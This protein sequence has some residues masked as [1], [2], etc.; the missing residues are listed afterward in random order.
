MEGLRQRSGGPTSLVLGAAYLRHK[1]HQLE[2]SVRRRFGGTTTGSD[3]E[4]AQRLSS[5]IGGG[6]GM[7]SEQDEFR[8]EDTVFAKMKARFSL[9]TLVVLILAATT[10]AFNILVMIGVGAFYAS[11]VGSILAISVGVSQLRLE[12]IETLRQVHNWMR[13]DVNR[14]TV[15]NI[16][17]GSSMDK[18][19]TK[20]ALLRHSEQRLE[21][22]ARENNSNSQSLLRLVQTNS[23]TLEAMRQVLRE[24]I[25]AALMNVAFQ[26]ERDESGEFSDVEIQRLLQYMRGLPAVKI[27]EE[28]LTQAIQRDRSIS[29]LLNLVRDISVPG[30]QEG[31]SIFIINEENRELQSIFKEGTV[32]SRSL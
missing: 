9:W 20:V 32:L 17:L 25:V 23:V 2:M 31:D 6:G 28:M 19:T 29:A 5:S 27:N 16:R 13:M 22:I 8:D 3:D 10:L 12:S 21:E 24:D 14:F 7:N 26:G 11:I 4:E 18:L 30:E 1:R 15:E